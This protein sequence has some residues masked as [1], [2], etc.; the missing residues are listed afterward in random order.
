MKQRVYLGSDLVLTMDVRI[1]FVF[2]SDMAALGKLS[3][4]SRAVLREQVRRGVSGFLSSSDLRV[5]LSSNSSLRLV[6]GRFDSATESG[7]CLTDRNISDISTFESYLC[8]SLIEDKVSFCARQ[9][10]KD[11]E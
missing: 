2:S 1:R 7:P 6:D 10:A 4:E 11:M 5:R 8:T 3:M 9:L